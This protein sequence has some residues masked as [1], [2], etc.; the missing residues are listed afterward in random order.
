MFA[1][2]WVPEQQVAPIVEHLLQQNARTFFLVGS[3]YAFGRGML[4]FAKQTIRRH[5]AQVVGEDYLPMDQGD[6]STVIAKIRA[7][8]ADALISATAGGEPNLELARQMRAADLKIPFGNL[9]IDEGTARDL[10]A[11]AAWQ[12]LSAS[13]FAS[14]DSPENKAFRLR[15]LVRFGAELKPPNEL[16]VPR[17]EAFHL[18]KAAAEAAGSTD[19]QQVL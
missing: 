4:D 8:R 12:L 9:S 13:Y 6:W 15:M 3:D 11:G 10:G 17:Y 2:G 5:V 19:A 1:N 16:S 7:S 18:Y 14:I